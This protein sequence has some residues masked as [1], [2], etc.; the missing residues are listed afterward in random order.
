MTIS[1][2]HYV[3]NVVWWKADYVVK[4]KYDSHFYHNL[5]IIGKLSVGYIY[6]R[7]SMCYCGAD[8]EEKNPSGWL[9]ALFTNPFNCSGVGKLHYI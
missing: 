1:L 8:T 9:S 7:V 2:R 6:A 3:G 5:I 4:E